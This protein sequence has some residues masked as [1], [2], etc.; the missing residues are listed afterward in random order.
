MWIPLLTGWRSSGCADIR[1]QV[2]S[3]KQPL[4]HLI[5]LETTHLRRSRRGQVL[6]FIN[7]CMWH[8]HS[9]RRDRDPAPSHRHCQMGAL[10]AKHSEPGAPCSPLG[11]DHL[12]GWAEALLSS[13]PYQICP[14]ARC[15]RNSSESW[16]WLL[17][18]CWERK[19][20]L[21]SFNYFCRY[22]GREGKRGDESLKT[23]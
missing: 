22:W 12:G 16:K 4:L 8:S 18:T 13:T 5:S 19:W 1:V 15:W 6:P 2:S 10:V 14:S 11:E 7:H 17:A 20:M 21:V 3:G 9:Q 23:H